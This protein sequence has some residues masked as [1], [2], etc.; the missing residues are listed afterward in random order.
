MRCAALVV[1]AAL[2]LAACSSPEEKLLE[3]RQA[4]RARLDEL[5]QRY[6]T[7][8]VAAG[9]RADPDEGR[10]AEPGPGL[11]QRLVGE[12]DRSHF[13]QYCLATGRGERAFALSAR[14]EGFA[15]EESNARG[16]RDAA[17]IEAE[18]AT[19]ERE[20]AARRLR[21]RADAR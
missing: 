3:R 2:A 5:H 11:V 16:C 8:E 9:P 18:V 15:R 13:E 1:A 20:V 4:L 12:L 19:L 21:E 10:P 6:A 17:R 7:T 14:L